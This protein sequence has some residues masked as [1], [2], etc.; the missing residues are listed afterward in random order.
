[1][2][3]LLRAKVTRYISNGGTLRNFLQRHTPL[4]FE[5]NR[6]FGQ[7]VFQIAINLV[8]VVEQI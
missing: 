3:Q 5:S 4:A 8:E 1:M 6:F 7:L 2:F